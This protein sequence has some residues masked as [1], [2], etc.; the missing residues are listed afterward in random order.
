MQGGE[1]KINGDKEAFSEAL[2][3]LIDNAVKYSRNQRIL[4]ISTYV[5]GSSYVISV[6]DKGLG[7]SEDQLPFIFD[8]FYRVQSDDNFEIKGTGLGLALV[9]NILDVHGGSVEVTSER[10]KGSEFRLYYPII[11]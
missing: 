11:S 2:V 9:K 1:V 8:Q 6:K 4:H 7:I 10:H 3:N 5:S